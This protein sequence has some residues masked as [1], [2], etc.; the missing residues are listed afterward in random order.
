MVMVTVARAML[1]SGSGSGLA[2]TT[3]PRTSALPAAAAL[4]VTM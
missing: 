1:F 4:T 3:A 2:D